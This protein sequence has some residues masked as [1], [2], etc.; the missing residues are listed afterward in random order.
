MKIKNSQSFLSLYYEPGAVEIA[1]GDVE[2]EGRW[3]G[4]TKLL[5][6]VE[7]PMAVA[8]L[9]ARW[10]MSASP[11][12][13]LDPAAGRGSLLHACRAMNADAQLVGVER[14]AAALRIAKDEAPRGTKLILADYVLADAGQFEGIISNPPYV[15]AHRLEY[16]DSDWRYFEER[17]GTPLDRFTN[18]YALFLLKIW[19]DLARKGRAAVILPSEFLNANFGEEIKE[20][21]VRTLRPA[22]VAI[23]SPV[24][25]LF[26][27]ALTT[28]AIVFL[29]KGYARSAV[30]GKKVESLEQANAFVSHLLGEAAENE[31][32]SYTDLAELHPR[33]KWLNQFFHNSASSGHKLFDR[34]VGDYFKCSRGIATGANNFFCFS[35]SDLRKHNLDVTHVEPC[36]TKA[37][38]ADGLLFSRENFMSLAAADRRCYLLNPKD[39]DSRLKDY[40][41]LGEQ[42]GIA[43]RHLPRHRPNWYL[44]E[45]RAVADIWVAVFSRDNVKFILN[46]SGAKNLTCFH[47]LYAKPGSEF[48]APLLTLFLNSSWGQEAFE[49]VNR[50]YGDGLNKLEPKDVEDMSCP[51]LPR[52]SRDDADAIVGELSQLGA[53]PADQRRPKID[54]LLL[55]CLEEQEKSTMAEVLRA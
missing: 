32:C 12:T 8:Q 37:G 52:M 31:H 48:T 43:V 2:G 44:P 6:Q 26:A 14:D 41:A 36:L 45:K 24:L 10:V 16:T 22:G 46:T 29:Q 21:L 7:T 13:I 38:D 28:S 35:A 3:K 19:E 33:D 47:G 53:I 50:F 25:N 55:K 49:Q 30:R 15:K 54:A 9:M 17:F 4:D 39:V 42:Q 20:R 18:L 1:T 23:F 5:G 34:R 40:L 11:T 27:N 51:E